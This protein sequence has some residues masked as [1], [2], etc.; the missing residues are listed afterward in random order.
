M[1]W[2][3]GDRPA[4]NYEAPA[5]GQHWGVCVGIFDIGTQL[6]KYGNGDP[7]RKV[8]IMFEFPWSL[9][10]DGKPMVMSI[11]RTLSLYEKAQL[12]ADLTSWFGR[13]LTEEECQNFDASQLLGQWAQLLVAPNP[14]SGK[15]GIQMILPPGDLSQY[16]M[17]GPVYKPT[18]FSVDEWDDQIYASLPS[19]IR[20][21]IDESLEVV[22]R[23]K[24]GTWNHFQAAPTAQAAPAPQAAAPAPAAPSG[25][26]Q[27]GPS[28]P[29]SPRPAGR[30][31]PGPS[32]PPVM[33]NQAPPAAPAGEPQWVQNAPHSVDMSTPVEDDS[34]PF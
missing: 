21:M 13:L 3:S 18:M 31:A 7:K 9:T 16:N 34:V 24:Q 4:G 6:N 29:G 32:G 14:V 1:K 19:G 23:K 12:R 22:E 11:F 30:P 25:P 33:V 5:P 15:V 20:R 8:V 28:F 2:S 17:P 26:P 10:K 27:A